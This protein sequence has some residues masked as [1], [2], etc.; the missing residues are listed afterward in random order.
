VY[1]R[2]AFLRV[3]LLLTT[4]FALSALPQEP[5]Q[6]A[7]PTTPDIPTPAAISQIRAAR[8]RVESYAKLLKERHKK[9]ATEFEAAKKANQPD[10][11][12]LKKADAKFQEEGKILDGARDRYI[13]AYSAYDGWLAALK[14]G[15]VDGKSK[16]LAKDQAYKDEA[17]KATKAATEFVE[18]AKPKLIASQRGTRGFMTAIAS[19]GKLGLDIWQQYLKGKE[20]RAKSYAEYVGTQIQWREWDKI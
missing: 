5:S 9:A 10:S 19:L 3:F 1:S 13:E 18:Y 17:A 16:A 12:A 2:T 6:P 8:T 7:T 14:A 4:S 15:I 20:E 11:E